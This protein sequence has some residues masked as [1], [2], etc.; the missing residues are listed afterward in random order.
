L[1]LL[2]LLLC[3]QFACFHHDTHHYPHAPRFLARLSSSRATF[4]SFTR[5]TSH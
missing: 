3:S 1:L 4:S 2:L 5:L